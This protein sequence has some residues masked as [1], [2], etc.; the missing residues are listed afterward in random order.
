MQHFFFRFIL[1]FFYNYKNIQNIVLF[2]SPLIQKLQ[3]KIIIILY[4][5]QKL[6]K[7]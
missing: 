5:L 2:F 1:F 7:G 6:N 4:M 3:Q